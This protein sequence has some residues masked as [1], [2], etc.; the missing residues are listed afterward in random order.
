MPNATAGS[1]MYAMHTFR[2]SKTGPENNKKEMRQI[3]LPYARSLTLRIFV[4]HD[5]SSIP[6]ELSHSQRQRI[7]RPHRRPRSPLNLFTFGAAPA[8]E[9][10]T[11]FDER[12]VAA[13]RPVVRPSNLS[14]GATSA[15][16]GCGPAFSPPMARRADGGNG[17]SMVDAALEA[18]LGAMLGA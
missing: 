18:T 12:S 2:K 6:L 11:T 16:R 3:R 8:G 10:L 9:D 5:P 14:H 15:F 17:Q 4:S 1:A 7:G 13:P